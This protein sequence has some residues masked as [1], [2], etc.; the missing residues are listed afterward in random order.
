[1][2][3][4]LF[5]LEVTFIDELHHLSH[6]RSSRVVSFEKPN[7][8]DYALAI[9]LAPHVTLVGQLFDLGMALLNLDLQ[10]GALLLALLLRKK[11][12]DGVSISLFRLLE[13]FQEN[14][15]HLLQHLR[16]FEVVYSCLPGW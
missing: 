12:T 9:M 16:L 14:F 5:A 15:V 7:L 3:A 8:L 4:H 10:L 1:M 13:L 6:I 11:L 2:S